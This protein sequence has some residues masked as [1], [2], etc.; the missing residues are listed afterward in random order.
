MFVKKKKYV[1]TKNKGKLLT[2][3]QIIL[4]IFSL[5]SR[6]NVSLTE[7]SRKNYSRNATRNSRIRGRSM[8]V[9][10]SP[11][12]DEGGQELR[13]RDKQ[14]ERGKQQERGKEKE[15]ESILVRGTNN[16][17]IQASYTRAHY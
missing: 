11:Y 1:K 12:G 2:C 4:F 10:G 8:Y 9:S 15:R 7:E 3:I 5:S 14:I 13:W 17:L 6:Y 16:A